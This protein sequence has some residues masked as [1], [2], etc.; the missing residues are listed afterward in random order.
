MGLPA[1]L[2]AVVS[3]WLVATTRFG[4]SCPV[5]WQLGST[6]A[7]VSEAGRYANILEQLV[8]YLQDDGFSDSLLVQLCDDA[9]GRSARYA[10]GVVAVTGSN[11]ASAQTAAQTWKKKAACQPYPTRRAQTWQKITFA[12]PSLL[13][14]FCPNSSNSTSMAAGFSRLH[15]Q[16]NECTTVQIVSGDS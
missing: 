4:L 12:I 5:R 8:D 6:L 11:L 10:L 15:Q 14:A 16:D 1:S 9:S 13:S 3:A 2:L 7:P